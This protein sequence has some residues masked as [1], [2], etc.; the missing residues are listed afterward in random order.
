MTGEKGQIVT[1]SNLQKGVT[2]R[3]HFTYTQSEKYYKY[4]NALG[5]RGSN[6]HMLLIAMQPDSVLVKANLYQEP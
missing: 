1:C 3:P 4:G 5:N 2:L 6:S